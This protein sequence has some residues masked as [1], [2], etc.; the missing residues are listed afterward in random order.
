MLFLKSTTPTL[1]A[2]AVVT[3]A[4]GPSPQPIAYKFPSLST[5]TGS[6][7]L[8]VQ[9]ETESNLATPLL[10]MASTLLISHENLMSG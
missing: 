1:M 9:S 8:V 10:K 2:F 5:A 4:H 6:N 3:N 7:L